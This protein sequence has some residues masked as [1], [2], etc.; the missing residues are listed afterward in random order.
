MVAQFL[1]A[2]P[3]LYCGADE[4]PFQLRLPPP[5]LGADARVPRCILGHTPGRP[6]PCWWTP[7]GRLADSLLGG[8]WGALW[9]ACGGRLWNQSGCL[10]VSAVSRLRVRNS[11]RSLLPLL[12]GI[13]PFS[14]AAPRTASAG[15]SLM[16]SIWVSRLVSTELNGLVLSS[17]STATS[18]AVAASCASASR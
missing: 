3:I 17:F 7:L 14:C 12:Y 18:A 1:S 4:Q 13:I 8:A 6:H 9:A 15:G 11:G 2:N 5:L 10:W 16:Q